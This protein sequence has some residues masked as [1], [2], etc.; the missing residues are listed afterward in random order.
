MGSTH[1]ITPIKLTKFESETMSSRGI[2]K[3]FNEEKGYGFICDDDGPDVF[4]HFKA[5]RGEGYRTLTEGQRVKF[6]V[7]KGYKGPQAE[8]VVV[9]DRY[10]RT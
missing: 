4:V 5:I 1:V 10:E 6:T 2:V 8:D 7:V 3:W 9:E